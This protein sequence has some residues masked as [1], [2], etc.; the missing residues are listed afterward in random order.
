MEY[1]FGMLGFGC[2]ASRWLKGFLFA[3]LLPS[4]QLYQDWLIW[5]VY[6]TRLNAHARGTTPSYFKLTNEL[7]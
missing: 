5:P 2:I 7:R 4:L 6:Q 3:F 1:A